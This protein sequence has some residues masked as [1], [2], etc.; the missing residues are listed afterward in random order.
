MH[1]NPT[2]VVALYWCRCSCSLWENPPL[3]IVTCV[4]SNNEDSCAWLAL[5]RACMCILVRLNTPRLHLWVPWL[6]FCAEAKSD[7]VNVLSR[8]EAHWVVLEAELVEIN[9]DITYCE[10][11]VQKYG[12]LSA[13]ISH[14]WLFSLY[15]ERITRCD[16][17]LSFLFI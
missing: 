17:E 11:C 6:V 7:L 5:A 8:L 14:V 1:G 3:F 13:S 16:C 12:Y 9:K 2:Y 10:Q 15:L 4:Y